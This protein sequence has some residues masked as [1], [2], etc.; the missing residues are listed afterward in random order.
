M[1]V[2]HP[3]SRHPRDINRVFPVGHSPMDSDWTH[4]GGLAGH[5]SGPVHPGSSAEN[6]RPKR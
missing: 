2:L 4:R 5:S 6:L 3:P 1:C